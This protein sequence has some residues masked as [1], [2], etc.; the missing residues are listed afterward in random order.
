MNNRAN[1]LDM[2]NILKEYDINNPNPLY[3]LAMMYYCKSYQLFKE[4]SWQS[5]NINDESEILSKSL[6]LIKTTNPESFLSN[7][8]L[9]FYWYFRWVERLGVLASVFIA[10]KDIRLLWLPFVVAFIMRMISPFMRF[11]KGTEYEKVYL[12]GAEMF[13]MSKLNTIPGKTNRDGIRILQR[14]YRFAVPFSARYFE[15]LSS[16]LVAYELDTMY[17][18]M[19]KEST[20]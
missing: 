18:E 14:M 12:I 6:A 10:L 7:K 11:I 5:D 15:S 1:K 20:D 8:T 9:K 19:R 2:E 3:L 4:T 16:L 13:F 17:Y